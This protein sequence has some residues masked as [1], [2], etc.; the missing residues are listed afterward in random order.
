MKTLTYLYAL[1]LAGLM[2]SGCSVGQ[3][4][5]MKE[6]KAPAVTEEEIGLRHSSLYTEEQKLTEGV[7]YKGEAPGMNKTY[8]R[9]FENAPPMIPHSVEDFLPITAGNN[10]CTGC[11]LP[12]IAPAMNATPIPASHFVDFRTQKKLD[13]LHQGRYNCSQC[14]TPQ[15]DRAPAVANTF[16]P[17]FREGEGAKRSNLLDVLNEGVR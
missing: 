15:A 12:E 11:H 8:D 6:E 7:T 17:E 1:A 10:A 14:H 2:V 5:T 9:A 16:D 3:R 13:G 4:Q